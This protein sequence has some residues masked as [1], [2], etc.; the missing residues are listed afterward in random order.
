MSERPWT[1][2]VGWEWRKASEIAQIVGGGT[3]SASDASN[4]DEGGVP[5]LTP[6]DLTGYDGTYIGRGRRNLS[7]KGLASCS[8]RVLPAGAV[9]Y[10]SR[11]PIGYCAIASNP[12]AT[13]QGFK[14]LILKESLVPEFVR[15]YLLASKDYA[16]SMAS[17]TTFK[18]LSAARLGELL[19]PIAPREV[20]T[21]IV[22]KLDSILGR[23]S[24]ARDELGKV[25][26]LIERYKQA[27][28]AAA[29][30]GNLT[31]SWRANNEPKPVEEQLVRKE[32][33]R[34]F[35][36][37]VRRY[38]ACETSPV[39]AP[40]FD[41]P[42]QWSWFRAEAV[43]DFI[44]KGTTPSSSAM[45]AGRGDVPFIK[46]YNLTFDGSL[47]FTVNPTFVSRHTHEI[48]LK[49]SQ[50]F[51]GDVL[52]N[53]VGPPLGKISIVPEAYAEWNINQAIA[54]F[55]PISLLRNRF[56]AYWLSTAQ[57]AGW[58]LDRSKATAGQS[59]LTLE[60]CRDIPV[61]MCSF[62]EQQEIVRQ[63]DSAFRRIRVLLEESVHASR[64]LDRL[65]QA[66]LARAFRG[67][68]LTP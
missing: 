10:S 37:K 12:I 60:I 63:I 61:P 35:A 65:D 59:N 13:N 47:D 39:G 40:P 6:A 67:E 52:M 18:E 8:A 5:W 53:I 21:D 55:R 62:P 15:Y 36:A 64:L 26:R 24:A 4:F 44:T 33:Q 3:P 57:A 27:V 32:R 43:C 58:A 51:P 46:V 48:V 9:L 50:V 41:I 31:T 28:L 17:G 30:S 34:Q 11:A 56:L 19:L 42:R 54:V 1:V 7:K 68:L 16:E 20:Q 2:P 23:S 22:T 25:P 49:R 45:T 38:E 66:T 14:N 29:F